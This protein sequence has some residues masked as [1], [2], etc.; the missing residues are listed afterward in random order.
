MRADSR[1]VHPALFGNA[2]KTLNCTNYSGER[3]KKT[4]TISAGAKTNP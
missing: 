4:G 2:D 3:C 1:S